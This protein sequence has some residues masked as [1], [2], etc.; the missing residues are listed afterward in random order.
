MSISARNAFARPEWGPK[1]AVRELGRPARKKS[2]SSKKAL[3]M[4][5]Y[6]VGNLGDEMM[7]VCL[8]EWLERQGFDLAVL[9]EN[10]AAVTQAH[11][12]P[13]V[14]NTPLLGEWSWRSSWL[15]GG[16]W[17]VI[18]ALAG[19]DALV[20]GGGDLIRDDLG[21][22]TFFFTMEKLIAAFLMRRKVYLVNTGI[23]QPST[24]YGRSLLKWTLRRCH[25]IIVR[26]ARSENVCR[27]LGVTEQVSL[28]PDIALSLPDLIA[29][30]PAAP[31]KRNLDPYVLVCLRHNPNTYHSYEL[32]EHRIRVLARALDELIERHD[33]DVVF[34]PL[35]AT[36][37]NGRGDALLH[38]RVARAM[39]HRERVRLRLWTA[40]L[41]EVCMRIRDARLVVAMRLHAAVLA[42][43]Y[44][45]PCVLM[46]YDRK[47]REFGDLM[48]IQHSIEAST[49]DDLSSV[50]VLLDSAWRTAQSANTA[51][52]RHTAASI[53]ADL[54]LETA[55]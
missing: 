43:A 48:G 51:D 35:H 2:L 11:G 40:D 25:R 32:T 44:G 55:N 37:P 45:L 38:G 13:A 16:A 31:M 34:L 29:A 50:N 24:W 28:A 30:Q 6:G 8:K 46:P 17:R 42:N 20:V 3:L 1:S 10:P 53:W 47:V 49:L 36:S 7:L 33:T 39:A 54:T 27:E 26:D 5:Y 23:G 9:S 12:L 21:W 52:M 4:G 19:C 41:K 18:K 22:R 14:Q 15:K